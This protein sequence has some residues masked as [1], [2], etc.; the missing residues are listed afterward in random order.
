MVKRKAPGATLNSAPNQAPTQPP[1]PAAQE[2]QRPPRQHREPRERRGPERDPQFIALE[3]R[4][5]AR[6]LGEF[7][8]K[9]Y[10]EDMKDRDPIR[11]FVESLD[12][13]GITPEQKAELLKSYVYEFIV[14]DEGYSDT[15]KAYALTEADSYHEMLLGRS[16]FDDEAIAELYKDGNL[17]T[18]EDGE[19]IPAIRVKFTGPVWSEF[20]KRGSYL[21][22]LYEDQLRRL[23]NSLESEQHIDTYAR[24]VRRGE[25]KKKLHVEAK[26][27]TAASSAAQEAT[28]AGEAEY[29]SWLP[30]HTAGD[31]EYRSWFDH[32]SAASPHPKSFNDPGQFVDVEYIPGQQGDTAPLP[33]EHSAEPS[34]EKS[35]LNAVTEAAGTSP[36]PEAPDVVRAFGTFD[37]DEKEKLLEKMRRAA[38][39]KQEIEASMAARRAAPPTP[40]SGVED[41]RHEPSLEPETPVE[42]SSETH[43]D[44]DLKKILE[45]LDIKDSSPTHAETPEELP[46]PP[47]E[48][49]RNKAPIPQINFLKEK[50]KADWT[51]RER[52]TFLQKLLSGFSRPKKK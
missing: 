41:E 45:E 34:L 44:G 26:S 14:P 46:E 9:E 33:P 30:E 47:L 24:D 15:N 19:K 25:V 20:T 43:S 36:L 28:D 39:K 11:Q 16:M 51:P 23:V 49:Q 27:S 21:S 31:L 13:P 52:R 2:S 5:V 38:A 40:E 4:L 17:M 6:N 18:A 37:R 8:G 50:N 29:R 42:S 48:T 12:A 1:Q 7:N 32:T 35:D 10:R 3:N 22:Q